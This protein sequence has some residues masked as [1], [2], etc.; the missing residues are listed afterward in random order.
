MKVASYNPVT[1]NQVSSDVTGIDFGTV[2]KGKHS[3]KVVSIRPFLDDTVPEN[4]FLKLALFL[5][6]NNGLSRTVFGKY[7]SSSPITGITPGSDYLSD[8][9]IQITGISDISQI[10]THSGIG[11]VFNETAPEYAW[12][13]AQV[14][15]YDSAVGQTNVNFRFIFEYN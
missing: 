4:T 5:E 10:D 7:K 3:S 15:L 11:L 14:G 9:F 8:Y 12:L 1:M 6:N 13:D 2:I